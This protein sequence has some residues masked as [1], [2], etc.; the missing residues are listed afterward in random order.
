MSAPKEVVVYVHGVSPDVNRTTSHDADYRAMHEGIQ[1]HNSNWPVNYLGVEWGWNIHQLE[2]PE[3]HEALTKAQRVFGERLFKAVDAEW[4]FTLNPTRFVING[5]RPI[6]FYGFGDMFY[7]V[8]MEGKWAIR[9]AVASRIVK[10]LKA[11]F[12]TEDTISLT[13]IGHSAGSVIAFDLL[14]HIFAEQKATPFLLRGPNNEE[15]LEADENVTASG[16]EDLRA[17]AENE[18]LRLR[19]L[20]TFGSPISMLTFRNDP[21]VQILSR[22]EYLNPTDYG[23]TSVIRDD[24]SL[25]PGPRW[26]NFWERDDPIA[27]PVAPLMQFGV[28]DVYVDVSDTVGDSHTAYWRSEDVHESIGKRW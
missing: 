22:G 4:D 2:N 21:L 20:I 10:Y 8:S 1:S 25:L 13:L 3:S 23:L 18:Q 12:A 7:Y 5:I 19:R 27:W 17:R 16:L 11:Q 26:V 24:A 9:L 28:E 6:M 15:V 14:Y